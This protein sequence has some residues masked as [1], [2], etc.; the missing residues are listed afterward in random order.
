MPPADDLT[1]PQAMRH[2]LL[3]PDQSVRDWFAQHLGAELDGLAS[4]LAKSFPHLQPML[5]AGERLNLPCTNLMIAFALGVIDDLMVSTKLLLAGQ[6]PG[7]GQRDATGAG[8]ARDGD[9]LFDRRAAR[10]RP[11]Q[12]EGRGSR[13]LLA[14]NHGERQ[15]RPGATRAA[16]AGLERRGALREPRRRRVPERVQKIFHPFSHCGRFTLASRA[17]LEVTG[18]FH[19]GGHFDAAKLDGYRHHL[20]QHT[21][22][23]G[24][25]PAMLDHLSETVVNAAPA[26]GVAA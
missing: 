24:V 1:D 2:E 4:G 15:S 7:V 10:D 9:P 5:D 17:A 11:R 26:A 16:P 3:D 13:L 21:G 14:E 22:L 18:R 6:L 8:R 20:E 23:A 19:L 12:E 25:L